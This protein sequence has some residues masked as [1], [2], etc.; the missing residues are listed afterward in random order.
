MLPPLLLQPA[1]AS[2]AS[3]FPDGFLLLGLCPGCC[4]SLSW[5][6]AVYTTALYVSGSVTPQ[7]SLSWLPCSGGVPLHTKSPESCCSLVI[8][9]CGR[10]LLMNICVTLVHS[11]GSRVL[12]EFAHHCGPSSC[13]TWHTQLLTAVDL[14]GLSALLLRHRPWSLTRVSLKKKEKNRILAC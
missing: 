1:L 9:V 3:S 14:G 5:Y 12:V 7:G 8:S 13:R 6:L 2:L 11:A 10:N 4:T